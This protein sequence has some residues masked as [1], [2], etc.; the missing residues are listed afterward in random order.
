LTKS[1]IVRSPSSLSGGTFAP[2]TNSLATIAFSL[3]R[4]LCA[5]F[6]NAAR[7][8]IGTNENKSTKEKRTNN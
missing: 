6:F 3:R 1:E 8:V 4:F 5:A 7:E 2:S